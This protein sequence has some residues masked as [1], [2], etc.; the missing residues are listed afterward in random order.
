MTKQITDRPLRKVGRPPIPYDEDAASEICARLSQGET[1][2]A[3]CQDQGLPSERTV[4]RWLAVEPTF[5]QL[6]ARAREAQME[7]WAD[8]ILEII[9]DSR[10]DYIARLNKSGES[11]SV[12][13]TENVQ[14]S[15]L[16]SDNRK[17]ILSKLLPKTFG[18]RIATEL[19][20]A[21]KVEEKP[22]DKLATARWIADL[23]LSADA[24]KQ[25]D[26]DEGN[27]E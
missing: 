6:Y 11:A 5:W 23:L 16:R 21:I 18:D 12:L 13:N 27:P 22:M 8:D 4:Y 7:K 15:R 24:A 10:N 3:I 19:T 20:G 14:R 26:D 9:D 2:S 17:W 25:A 1:M